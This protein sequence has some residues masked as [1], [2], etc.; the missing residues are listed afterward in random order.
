MFMLLLINSLKVILFF[1]YS[2]FYISSPEDKNMRGSYVPTWKKNK[3]KMITL[4][5]CSVKGLRNTLNLLFQ[6]V[7]L[8][9]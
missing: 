9:Q 3:T 8:E 4:L 5:N 1:S 2:V 6:F 7:L